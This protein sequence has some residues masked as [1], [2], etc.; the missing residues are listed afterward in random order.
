MSDKLSDVAKRLQQEY[1]DTHGMVGE[2]VAKSKLERS[3]RYSLHRKARRSYVVLA[4]QKIITLKRGVSMADKEATNAV[5]ILSQEYGY[6]VQ[7]EIQ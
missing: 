4:K 3:K 5:K 6:N 7:G 2:R 1:I